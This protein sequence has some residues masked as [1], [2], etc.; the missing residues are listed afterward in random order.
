MYNILFVI[1]VYASVHACHLEHG[2]SEFNDLI[3]PWA[4]SIFRRYLVEVC[5]SSK[6]RD[7]RSI[8][9]AGLRICS[10]TPPIYSMHA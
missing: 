5:A 1:V 8:R 9:A 2:Y 3:G 10:L 7:A 4:V 6:S